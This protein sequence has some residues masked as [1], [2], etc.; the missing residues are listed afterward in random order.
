MDA[1]LN[2]NAGKLHVPT[3]LLWGYTCGAANLTDDHF[4]HLLFC[5]DCQTMVNQFIDVLD[6]IAAAH[7]K[8]VA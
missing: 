7:R 4:E 5:L 1:D 8:N 3:M 2:V 6:E